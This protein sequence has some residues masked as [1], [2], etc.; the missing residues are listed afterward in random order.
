M[1]VWDF[2]FRKMC[3]HSKITT[4]R[5]LKLHTN[6]I[7][8][9]LYVLQTKISEVSLIITKGRVFKRYELKYLNIL[10]RFSAFWIFLINGKFYCEQFGVCF[11]SIFKGVPKESIFVITRETWPLTD[12]VLLGATLLRQYEVLLLD[13]AK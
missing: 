7:H 1:S 8:V 9:I 13:F 4:C 3:F 10:S 5:T 11:D 6:I 2:L 12:S